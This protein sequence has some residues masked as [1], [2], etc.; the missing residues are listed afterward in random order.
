MKIKDLIL[1]KLKNIN[2]LKI[3]I[4]MMF[5]IKN[6]G[7]LLQKNIIIRKIFL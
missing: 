4:G 7:K 2:F 1:N 5:I 3:L 6:Q